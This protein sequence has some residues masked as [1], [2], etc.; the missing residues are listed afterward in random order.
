MSQV[1][2]VERK[3]S[4]YADFRS[5]V[6]AYGFS[7]NNFYDVVFHISPKEIAKGHGLYQELQKNPATLPTIKLSSEWGITELMR[8]YT[9]EASLPGIQMSTGEYRINN[10]PQLK[11]A[12]GS[13]FSEINFTFMMDADSVIKS[14]FDVWTNWIYA[15]SAGTS[16][17]S[18]DSR[19]RFRSH[20][21]DD[22]CV[23]IDII[24][25][26]K[27]TSSRNNKRINFNQGAY[28]LYDIVPD[29]KGR[30][31]KNWEL[32][33]WRRP[34]PTHAVKLYNAFP[35]NLAST[36]LAYGDTSINKLSVGFEYE[37]YTTTALNNNKLNGAG[38]N[39]NGGGYSSAD[40]ARSQGRLQDFF[41]IF[42]GLT[43]A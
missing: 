16:P 26:E 42:G 27:A 5:A 28:K 35:V 14:V 4:N 6:M 32:Q 2:D 1:R 3:M 36:P 38:D 17:W 20:Y 41:G 11:Y 24:K 34:V 40:L 30:T 15:Y 39:I 9:E 29:F 37:H 7:V 23:D 12:Y 22:Y 21:R 10:T 19:N 43:F 25:Y 31:N 8:L 18:S 13:V 33:E